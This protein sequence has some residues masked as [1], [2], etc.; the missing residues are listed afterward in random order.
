MSMDRTD[1]KFSDMAPKDGL[2]YYR[3]Q[4]VDN[5]ASS[6]S[7]RTVNVLFQN[8]ASLFVFPNPATE[9]L[10]ASLG[11]AI[12]GTVRWRILDMSGRLVG[13]GSLTNSEGTTLFT[14]PVGNLEAGSYA[15]EV[16]EG[17]GA[18]IGNVRFVKQ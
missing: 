4:Q 17:K 8:T 7:S 18:P 15:L 11:R 2:N 14:V 13:E 10:Q 12:E 3:L 1:Y 6:T 5:D 16:L 9:T